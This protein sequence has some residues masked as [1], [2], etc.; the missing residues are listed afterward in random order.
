MTCYT[1]SKVNVIFGPNDHKIGVSKV[2]SYVNIF[3]STI[4]FIGLIFF[5][6]TNWKIGLEKSLPDFNFTE[7]WAILMYGGLPLFVTGSA[8]TIIF[9]HYDTVCCSCCCDCCCWL[10]LLLWAS[11]SF[12]AVPI[13]VSAASFLLLAAC[14]HLLVHVCPGVCSRQ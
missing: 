2:W 11:S 8:L 1:L 4:S 5:D 10:P 12:A 9:L 7:Y 6:G 3:I 14:I 13:N